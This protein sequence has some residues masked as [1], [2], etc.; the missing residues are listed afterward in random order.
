M[1]AAPPPP[2]AQAATA[3]GTASPPTTAL[4]AGAVA[5]PR[6]AKAHLSNQP[7]RGFRCRVSAPRPRSPSPTG[8][9]GGGGAAA[10]AIHSI[11]FSLLSRTLPPSLIFSSVVSH[12]TAHLHARRLPDPNPYPGTPFPPLSAPRG[13]G[14]AAAALP[15]RRDRAGVAAAP[16]GSLRRT[17]GGAEPAAATGC[18]RQPVGASRESAPKGDRIFL[19]PTFFFVSTYTS[20]NI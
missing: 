4:K 20:A 5:V 16:R 17:G 2:P 15:A 1:R 9:R 12:G 8:S 10:L 13:R 11:P 6:E 3:R 19:L 18:R 7:R 14:M